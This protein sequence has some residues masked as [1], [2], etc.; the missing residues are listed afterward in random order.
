L[1]RLVA[2]EELADLENRIIQREVEERIGL[3]IAME[4]FVNDPSVRK[5][6]RKACGL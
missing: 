6:L 1:P 4:H 2:P 5:L 3:R